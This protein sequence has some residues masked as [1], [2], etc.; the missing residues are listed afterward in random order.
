MP[1]W[2]QE[3]EAGHEGKLAPGSE[4]PGMWCSEPGVGWEATGAPSCGMALLEL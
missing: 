1:S 4:G 2:E 3:E